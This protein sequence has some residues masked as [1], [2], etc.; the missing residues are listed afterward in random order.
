MLDPLSQR[1][2][3]AGSK[4]G[5]GQV[6]SVFVSAHQGGAEVGELPQGLADDGALI[7]HLS[8]ALPLSFSVKLADDPF[9]RLQDRISDAGAPFDA[10]GGE[11]RELARLGQVTDAIVA[12]AQ[13]PQPADAMRRHAVENATVDADRLQVIE[14]VEHAV[15][16][17]RVGAGLELAQPD[18]PGQLV[19]SRFVEQRQ[20][21]LG[22]RGIHPIG[23]GFTMARSAATRASAQQ[24]SMVVRPG[25]MILR[26]LSSA[27]KSAASPSLVRA[28][29]AA[30]RSQVRVSW[31]TAPSNGSVAVE[32]LQGDRMLVTRRPPLAVA[33][34]RLAGEAD[35]GADERQ[36]SFGDH[37][38]RLQQ[39]AWV[40]ERA[41]L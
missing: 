1:R 6:L 25:M 31:R 18:E 2:T 28:H 8:F 4:H 41:Q 9:V 40:A 5:F 39:A 21:P 30:A 35:L 13:T 38:A 37:F 33:G 16:V 23:D 11:D 14:P 24:R 3:P 27:T 19:I 15:D 26:R 10:A 22:G 20:Q 12:L 32:L 17:G 29:S 36:H 34:K 7:L